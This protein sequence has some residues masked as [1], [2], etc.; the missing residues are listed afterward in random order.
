VE[1]PVERARRCA[2]S[3]RHLAEQADPD[4]CAALDE[5]MLRYGQRWVVPQIAIY[6]DDDLLTADLVADFAGVAQK[7][8]YE[9]RRL[10]DLP[11]RTTPDGIRFRFADVIRWLAERGR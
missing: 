2:S 8:V 7:T 6:T 9:W 3:Y 10:H 4:G 5:Q 1:Q 11:S